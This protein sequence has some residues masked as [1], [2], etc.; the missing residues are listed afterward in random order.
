MP[1][2]DCLFLGYACLN[3]EQIET[4]YIAAAMISISVVIITFNEEKNIERCID[5]VKKIAD[6]VIVIDSFST[7]K[8]SDIAE[9]K[10]ARIIEHRFEGYTAQKSFAVQQ[11]NHDFILSLDA[12]EYLSPKLEQSILAAKSTWNA[13]GYSMK[14]LNSYSGK[15]I[16]S[17]GWY[18]DKK[19]RLFDRK[20]GAW[21]GDLVHEVV[22]MQENARVLHLEGDL[23]HEAYQN[24]SQLIAKMQGRYADLF[25]KQYAHKKQVT[26]FKIIYKTLASFCKSYFLKGGIWDGYEGLVISASNANGVFYKYAKLLEANRI[27]RPNGK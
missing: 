5:S 6:E 12:D 19:I 14:R 4:F 23:L 16:K 15:W 2:K 7:D 13:D 3:L 21:Q 26:P 11:A 9:A 18:P 22:E 10:G 8:T 1:R 24:A 25:A 27:K 20:K 17:C